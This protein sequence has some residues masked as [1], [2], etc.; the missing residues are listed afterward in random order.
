MSPE[1]RRYAQRAFITVI[2]AAVVLLALGFTHD[3]TRYENCVIRDGELVQI[4][5][6]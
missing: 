3:A 1:E 5:R 4:C 6:R 2:V